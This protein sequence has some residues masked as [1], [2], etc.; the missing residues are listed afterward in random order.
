VQIANLPTLQDDQNQSDIL[1]SKRSALSGNYSQLKT[2]QR[3]NRDIGKKIFNIP[4]RINSKMKLPELKEEKK[5]PVLMKDPDELKDVKAD[6]YI[7]VEYPS[8]RIIVSHRS[9]ISLEIASLTKIMTFYTVISLANER[10]IDITVTSIQ[11]SP[12]VMH[13]TGTSAE[14]IEGEEYTVQE[15][16]YGLMLPSGNDAANELAYW[17]G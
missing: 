12:K 11:V 3:I 2:K 16:L 15:L 13:I 1:I 17:G 8:Q 9:V 7:I 4:D 10:N 5:Y 6:S 14:L